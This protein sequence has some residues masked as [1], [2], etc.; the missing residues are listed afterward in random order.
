MVVASDT[1]SPS[2]HSDVLMGGHVATRDAALLARVEAWRN[3]AGTIPPGPQEAW[4][5]HRGGLE[6]LEVRFDRMCSSAQV[7]AER[8]AAHPAVGA[9]RYPPGLP[10]DPSHNLARQ[11]MTRMGGF[12]ISLTLKDEA[13]AERFINGCPPLLRP[14]TSFGG[15]HSSA[16][17]RARWGGDDVPPPASC[18]CRWAWNRSRSF[19]P[20]SNPRSTHSDPPFHIGIM[21]P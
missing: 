1:K 16:E 12:L 8:M 3:T 21:G 10:G 17:R 2:G 7:I 4:L 15:V 11:Q 9:V 14:A 19:G 18:A 6:T 5:T 20:R 13:T